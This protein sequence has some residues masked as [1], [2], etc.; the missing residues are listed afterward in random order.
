MR[1]YVSE[2]TQAV[3]VLLVS[4]ALPVTHESQWAK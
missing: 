1:T 3:K 2:V 4:L